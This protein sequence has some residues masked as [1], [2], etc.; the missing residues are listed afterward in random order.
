VRIEPVSAGFTSAVTTNYTYANTLTGLTLGNTGNTQSMTV[1]T[2]VNIA[3]PITVYGGSVA[4]SAALASSA[5]GA[6]VLLK[7]LGKVTSGANLTTN[8]GDITLW[9]NSAGATTGGIIVNNGT[10]LSSGGG[11]ITL[12]GSVGS[13]SGLP[14]TSALGTALPQGYAKN[15]NTITGLSLG[16]SIGAVS[17]TAN[18]TVNSGGGRVGMA[19]E[20]SVYGLSGSDRISFGLVAYNGVNID[21][22]SGDL[23]AY[24]LTSGTPSG[25]NSFTAALQLQPWASVQST[26]SV[27]KTSGGNIVLTGLSTA[28]GGAESG[29]GVILDGTVTAPLTIENIST[30]GGSVTFNGAVTGSPVGNPTDCP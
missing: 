30:S 28:S 29:R 7:A 10:T 8:G 2:A 26:G 15:A 27:W 1:G 13:I 4:T 23:V 6:G 5:S 14:A 21:T 9:A 17:Q 20:S 12:G 3:G 16:S 24:G 18:I 25:G 19:G 11:W 22:G